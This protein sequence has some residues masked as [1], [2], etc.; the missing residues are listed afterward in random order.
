MARE[1][2]R[3]E[4]SSCPELRSDWVSSMGGCIILESIV[5][6][7][8]LNSLADIQTTW[9]VPTTGEPNNAR[10]EVTLAAFEVSNRPAILLD[11]FGCVLRLNAAA[12]G[13]LGQDFFIRERRVRSARQEICNALEDAISQLLRQ[14]SPAKL[15]P[16]AMVRAEG[17]PVLAHYAPEF[18]A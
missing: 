15:Q 18:V 13:V 14:T 6:S 7:E 16:I 1:L 10:V 5:N 12:E 11:Q 4:E 8:E 2:S 9:T 17:C 3:L